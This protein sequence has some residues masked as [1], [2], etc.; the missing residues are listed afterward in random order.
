MRAGVDLVLL[1]VG[2]RWAGRSRSFRSRSGAGADT[3]G[4][5]G[6]L[7]EAVGGPAY[8]SGAADVA[9]HLL[10]RSVVSHPGRVG[11]RWAVTAAP[12]RSSA[13]TP[14]I[15]RAATGPG[16]RPAHP[17]SRPAAPAAPTRTPITVPHGRRG[18]PATAATSSPSAPTGR[19]ASR[20]ARTVSD[21]RG[22]RC[23][24]ISPHVRTC[25]AGS[26]QRRSRLSHNSV[27]GRPPQGRSRTR[28]G[29]R[30]AE[31]PPPHSRR[32]RLLRRSPAPP[33]RAHHRPQP[34]PTTPTRASRARPC[35]HYRC[36]TWGLLV[37]ERLAATLTER[38]GTCEISGGS[39]RVYLSVR[40]SRWMTRRRW[41][42]WH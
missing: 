2:A 3:I 17:R 42:S 22:R 19:H 33:A 16:T 5:V 6:D 28:T 13:P 29:L 41:N 40:L 4:D 12:K 32:T 35:W 30:H 36:G 8:A 14:A 10:T 1:P 18:R 15:A 20:R 39:G 38:D 7:G 24:H 23:V 27:T 11:G 37:L 31:S 34:P 25:H 21:A 9:Q 26:A